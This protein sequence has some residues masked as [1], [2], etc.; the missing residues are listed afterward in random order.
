MKR[1]FSECSVFQACIYA[2]WPFHWKLKYAVISLALRCV[3]TQETVKFAD[4]VNLSKLTCLSRYAIASLRI[5][6]QSVF[7]GPPGTDRNK[8]RGQKNE[9]F[10]FSLIFFL[11][12]KKTRSIFFVSKDSSRGRWTPVSCRLAKSTSLSFSTQTKSKRVFRSSF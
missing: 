12:R 3:W 5:T 4:L 2:N 1:F 9:A 11:S 8:L 10:R 7:S 6:S